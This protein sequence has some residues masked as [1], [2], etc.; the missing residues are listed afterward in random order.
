MDKDS[1]IIEEL[2]KLA[3]GE[4]LTRRNLGQQV[5]DLVRKL[6]V[7]GKLKIGQRLVE[8]RL[9][10]GLG[11]SRT[12]V[13]EALHRLAQ[14]ELLSKR[15]RGGYV[16]RPLTPEEVEDA[17]GL[18]AVLEAYAAQ[19][20]AQRRDPEIIRDIENNLDAFDQALLER[21]ERK[22][23]ELN[24]EF[25][26]LL[27]QAA[28]SKLLSRQLGDLETTVER[29]SRA[30][31]SNMSAGEWSC[32]EHRAILQAIKEGDPEQAAEIA[33]EHV[34]RGGLWIVSRMREE[35]LEL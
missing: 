7:S 19:R 23:I 17:E 15:T 6:V 33:R 12:P 3:A 31:I 11:I 20:A 24:S 1:Q 14:E 16:V 30:L 25:H 5:T 34:S 9:A 35:N 8:Q 18:R 32:D 22:L 2:N 13:R 29:I 21:D 28:R 4:G 27:H 26:H 10:E